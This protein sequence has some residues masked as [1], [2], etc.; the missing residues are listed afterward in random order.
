MILSIGYFSNVFSSYFLKIVVFVKIVK[1]ELE[2][3][4]GAVN[5]SLDLR[6]TPPAIVLMAGLQGAGKT[7]ALAHSS[8]ILALPRTIHEICDTV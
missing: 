8:S 1:T 7:T 4:M 2:T 3:A 5:E 6:A